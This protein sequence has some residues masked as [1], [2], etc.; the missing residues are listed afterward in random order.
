[1]TKK[2]ISSEEI[3]KVADLARISLSEAEN[4]KFCLE[5]D[6]ILEYFKDLGNVNVKNYQIFDHHDQKYNDFRQDA[7]KESPESE[8][9]AM[10]KSFPQKSGKYLKVKAVLN[11]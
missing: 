6:S 3:K 4:K 5:I 9:K 8:Q 10:I 1:M 2:I 11:S 7:V